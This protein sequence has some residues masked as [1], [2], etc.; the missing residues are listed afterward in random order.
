MDPKNT[1]DHCPKVTNFRTSNNFEPLS[2][3]AIFGKCG[4]FVRIFQGSDM[5]GKNRQGPKPSLS[6]DA[7]AKKENEDLD[8]T[9]DTTAF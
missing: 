4:R 9:T 5:I 1:G 3:K 8:H 2:E 6:N 7:P